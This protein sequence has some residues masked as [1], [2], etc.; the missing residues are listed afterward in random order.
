M[1]NLLGWVLWVLHLKRHPLD[2]TREEWLFYRRI[3]H[4]ARA[5]DPVDGVLYIPVEEYEK[6]EEMLGR[7]PTFA[8]HEEPDDLGVYGYD[9]D[10]PITLNMR[11]SRHELTLRGVEH[12]VV[13]NRPVAPWPHAASGPA[14]APP[15]RTG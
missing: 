11:S 12:L 14:V 9:Y 6:L 3:R 15:E 2:Y 1:K 5:L 7:V 10:K 8:M 13:G 4:G